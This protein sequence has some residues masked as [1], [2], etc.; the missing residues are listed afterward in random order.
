MK[1]NIAIRLSAAVAFGFITS[2]AM[3]DSP[4]VNKEKRTFKGMAAHTFG[5]YRV[6]QAGA[7]KLQRQPFGL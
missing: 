7:P 5:A 4:I 3:A 1:G 6:P 2:N